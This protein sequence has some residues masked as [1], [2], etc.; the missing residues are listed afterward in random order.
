MLDNYRP[1][2]RPDTK[3]K[4]WIAKELYRVDRIDTIFELSA[5]LILDQRKSK[6][7]AA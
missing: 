4:C 2:A 7:R 1:F 5:M 6:E 3:V